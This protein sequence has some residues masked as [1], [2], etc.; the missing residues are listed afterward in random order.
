L[1]L[2]ANNPVF[3]AMLYPLKFSADGKT[4][5][6]STATSGDEKDIVVAD[7]HPAAFKKMLTSI[8]TDELEV[9]AEDVTELIALAKRFQVHTLHRFAQRAMSCD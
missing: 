5:T 9:A 2:A 1:I 3:R 8:Y 4:A 6:Y 7:V